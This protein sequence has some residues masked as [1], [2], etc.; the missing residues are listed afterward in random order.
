M[1]IGSCRQIEIGFMEMTCKLPIPI[2]FL[3][4][5]I[6]YKYLILTP[7]RQKAE[8]WYEVIPIHHGSN[9]NRA[10]WIPNNKLEKCKGRSAT[11]KHK[12]F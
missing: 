1:I 8:D 7:K 6:P 3:Q 4:N 5:A 11:V 12:S 10:L 2:K 9:P